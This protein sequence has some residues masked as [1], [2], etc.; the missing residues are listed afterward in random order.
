M[1]IP[2]GYQLEGYYKDADFNEKWDDIGK[3]LNENQTVYIKI[4]EKAHVQLNYKVAQGSGSVSPESEKLNPEIGIA[5]GSTA[6]ADDGWAFDGWYT[7]EACTDKID[8]NGDPHYTPTRPDTGWVDDTTY[9]A[10]FVRVK[11]DLTI[12]KQ[13]T[14]N[15]GDRS[16]SFEFEVTSTEAMTADDTSYTLST[17]GKTATFS[18]TS[19]NSVTLKDVTIGADLTISEKNATGYTVTITPEGSAIKQDN[20]SYKVTVAGANTSLTVINRKDAI[21]DMGVLLDSLPYILILAVVVAVGAFVFIR[22]RREH[23]D[24]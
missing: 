18:L 24:D 12:T 3:P 2:A 10:K 17:D 7:D 13:V 19:G 5:A 20:G 6:T 22:K 15:M 14:G 1:K 16:K 4:I 9:W 23:D 21:P 8:T 11:V